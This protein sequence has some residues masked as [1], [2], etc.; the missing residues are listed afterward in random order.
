VVGIAGLAV[1]ATS[2]VVG[3][4]NWHKLSNLKTEEAK[5]DA[6]ALAAA[7]NAAAAQA[8]AV[9]ATNEAAIANANAILAGTIASATCHL[10]SPT[11]TAC[12]FTPAH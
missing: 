8:A 12:T 2:A 10:V 4:V 5:T 1:G 11:D 7:A 6:D 3:F 9:A